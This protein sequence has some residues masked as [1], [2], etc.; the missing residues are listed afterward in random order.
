MATFTNNT[1][2]SASFTNQSKGLKAVKN[3]LMS[4]FEDTTF[5]EVVLSDG[6][7]LKNA[8]FEDL[9]DVVWASQ[10]KN[11]ATFTNNSQS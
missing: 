4:E 9:I 3:F 8:T 6:T 7:Q 1:R 10:S 2:N 5:D 11:S